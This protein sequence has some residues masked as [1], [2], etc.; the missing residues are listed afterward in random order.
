MPYIVASPFLP[1]QQVTHATF[2]DLAHY[3]WIASAGWAGIEIDEFPALK[4]WEE[5]MTA[6]P[7]VEKGRHVPDPHTIKELLKDKAKMEEHA[8]KSRA[9]VQKGMKED[10]AKKSEK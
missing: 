4:A 10:A 5:R 3:G 9:W 2:T 7:G 1:Y 6:R 8:A